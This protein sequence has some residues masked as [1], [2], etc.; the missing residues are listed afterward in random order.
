MISFDNPV[1]GV[2]YYFWE[3]IF[4][5]ADG[6][7]SQKWTSTD[8]ALFKEYRIEANT[9]VKTIRLHHHNST[10]AL[11]SLMRGIEFLD[12]EDKSVLKAG[13]IKQ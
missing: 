9:E 6:S 11:P 7:K 3:F 10:T 12:W 4:L 1:V 2:A 8:S 5:Y 13:D